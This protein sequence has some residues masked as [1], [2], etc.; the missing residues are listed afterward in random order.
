MGDTSQLVK[1]ID[2]C[3]VCRDCQ[4][5]IDGSTIDRTVA[6]AG[7]QG[8]K[9]HAI[10]IAV[11]G[12]SVAQGMGT[13]TAVHAKLSFLVKNDLLEPL[14][15]HWLFHVSLLGKKPGFWTHMG[16]AGIPVTEDIAADTFRDR[17]IPVRVV[18]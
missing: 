9:V 13:E 5:D 18:F 7:F 1:R 14:F 12:I 16:G 15:I 17:D 8:K 10:L 11:G 2:D 6:E 3:I 4:M